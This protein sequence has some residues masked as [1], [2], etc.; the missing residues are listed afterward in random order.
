MTHPEHD[1]LVVGAGPAGL[2]TAI[3]AARHG[4]RVLLVERRAGLS[5][6]P[7]ATG[8]STR[9]MEILRTW[10]VEAA[11]R[12]GAMDAEPVMAIR[13]SLTDPPLQTVPLGYP[14]V[15]QARAV[16]PVAPLC[17]PQD[18]VERVLLRCLDGL[19]GRI[20]F[21]CALT[22]ITQD[23]DGVRAALS[24][25]TVVRSR[26]VVGADG[27]RSVVR[28]LLDIGIDEL[29]TLADFL[30]VQFRADLP[31]GGAALN[32]IA[33]LRPNAM[34]GE[35]LLPAG[36]GRWMYARQYRSGDG[37]TVADWPPTRLVAA[38]RAAAGVPDLT[39]AIDAVFPFTTT[40][41]LAT[42]FRAGN[43]F[44]V[45][46]AA[47]RMTPMGGTGLNTAVHSGH[48]LGWR[49]AWAA[50]GLGGDA[51][52][53]GYE[54]E[55]RPVGQEN[56]LRSLGRGG[57]PGSTGGLEHDLGV[58]YGAVRGADVLTAAAAGARAPHVPVRW[59]GRQVSTLDLFDGRLT[60]LT[61]PAGIGWRAAAAALYDAGLPLAALSAGLDLRGDG[62]L[63]R[64]Y[65]LGDR[66][67]VLVRPDGHCGPALPDV[68]H[69]H[70][71]GHLDVLTGAV[72]AVLGTA[73]VPALAR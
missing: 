24:D 1:V 27:A 46:D 10:G 16:S 64:R 12:A 55:R 67:A 58:G 44:L 18:H 25:G 31:T 9:T 14:T 5:P 8:V 38:I 17:C 53:D 72:D 48:N 59:A 19:G 65:G 60:L 6:Y 70:R 57:T 23:A 11:V 34:P 49:L 2:A 54:A 66:A 73:R 36:S 20:R 29:G 13:R 15:D 52:L 32:V 69:G 68:G 62:E 7:R 37:E 26:F 22:G 3:A 50:R 33:G 42:A 4:A 51:L 39:V 71:H 40:G 41:A 61:G 43:G 56:V 28:A 45:G 63:V 30:N 47:H 21:S 35:V